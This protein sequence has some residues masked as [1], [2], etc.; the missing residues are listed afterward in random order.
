MATTRPTNIGGPQKAPS[1]ATSR[2][3]PLTSH[4]SMSHIVDRQSKATQPCQGKMQPATRKKDR[5]EMLKDMEQEWSD[6]LN[7]LIRKLQAVQRRRVAYFSERLDHFLAMPTSTQRLVTY[8]TRSC[9]L[10]E[11]WDG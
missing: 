10:K 6:N 8:L 2:N 11:K 9:D 7:D 4:K 1:A 5:S 3:P